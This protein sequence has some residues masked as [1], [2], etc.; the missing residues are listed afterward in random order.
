[1]TS[2]HTVVTD[3]LV[4]TEFIDAL[5]EQGIRVIIA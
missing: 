5:S 1:L 4:R 2:V 3:S